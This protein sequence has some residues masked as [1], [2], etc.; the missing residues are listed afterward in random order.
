M[1][2]CKPEFPIAASKTDPLASGLHPDN[3]STP[4]VPKYKGSEGSNHRMQRKEMTNMPLRKYER[5][6]LR[7]L[8]VGPAA[9]PVALLPT[10]SLSATV[11]HP[12]KLQA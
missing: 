9:H 3:F 6:M 2:S 12:F 10:T 11:A 7:C 4:S 1:G 8:L 5:S